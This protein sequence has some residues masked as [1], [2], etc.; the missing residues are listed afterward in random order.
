MAIRRERNRIDRPPVPGERAVQPTEASHFHS[1]RRKRSGPDDVATDDDR[2]ARWP[3]RR[4]LGNRGSPC[5]PFRLYRVGTTLRF[6]SLSRFRFA[7][8]A[9]RL[10]ALLFLLLVLTRLL[11]TSSFGCFAFALRSFSGTLAF[12]IALPPG[13]RGARRVL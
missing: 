10:G 3:P 8:A 6:G 7:S 12:G 5:T 9:L 1:D 4:R 13:I 2:T 11:D